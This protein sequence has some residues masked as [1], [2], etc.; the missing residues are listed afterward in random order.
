MLRLENFE[1]KIQCISCLNKQLCRKREW[2]REILWLSIELK[3][4]KKQ[5]NSQTKD[6]HKPHFR[7]RDILT[8]IKI[9]MGNM[10]HMKNKGAIMQ[11]KGEVP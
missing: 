6:N 10:L 5:T 7:F 2:K 8:E 3:Q 4:N 11:N 1:S 9:E